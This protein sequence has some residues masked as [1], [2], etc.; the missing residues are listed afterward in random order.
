[1]LVL[2]LLSFLLLVLAWPLGN[3]VFPFH[4]IQALRPLLCWARI[5]SGL[6]ILAWLLQLQSVFYALSPW[7]L[8][9]PAL[10]SFLLLTR[11]RLKIPLREFLWL[12]LCAMAASILTAGFIDYGDSGIYHH[13]AMAWQSR[14]GAVP[15][16]AL[17]CEQYGYH[18]SW[19]S[20]PAPFHHGFLT[21]HVSSLPATLMTA[22]LLMG[23]TLFLFPKRSFRHPTLSLINTACLL[24]LL[25]LYS[26]AVFNSPNPD[27]GIFLGT[28][29]L[30]LGILL[31]SPA[32]RPAILALSIFVFSV[33]GS[34]LIWIPIAYFL[35]R[36]PFKK[37]LTL[38]LLLPPAMQSILLSGALF[39]PLPLLPFPVSWAPSFSS[40]LDS[41]QT[42]RE[43][44]RW[45]GF[46]PAGAKPWDW[47]MGWTH[48]EPLLSFSLSTCLV[49]YL[50]C[51]YQTS[52]SRHKRLF[53]IILGLLAFSFFS[54][55]TWR[56]A[57]AL[58]TLP[59][60]LWIS[61]PRFSQQKKWFLGLGFL[62]VGYLMTVHH[63]HLR[64][65]PLWE[66]LEARRQRDALFMEGARRMDQNQSVSAACFMEAACQK[67]PSG[68]ESCQ[69]L[70]VLQSRFHPEDWQD[71]YT[72]KENQAS[73]WL[74]THHSPLAS[75]WYLPPEMVY[76]QEKVL[77]S[78]HLAL[79][80]GEIDS[81]EI[82]YCWSAPLP[83]LTYHNATEWTYRDQE[84]HDLRYGFTRLRKSREFQLWNDQPYRETLLKSG[85]QNIQETAQRLCQ[86]KPGGLDCRVELQMKTLKVVLSNLGSPPAFEPDALDGL[87]QCSM[88]L[89]EQNWPKSLACAHLLKTAHPEWEEARRLYEGLIEEV[90]RRELLRV[91]YQSPMLVYTLPTMP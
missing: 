80:A 30:A 63:L 56:Y 52:F 8:L 11:L 47:L 4:P 74:N 24:L 50:S 86:Q 54:S 41:T 49:F 46:P 90:P 81:Q 12:L 18:S 16:L 10:S 53:L 31:T 5:G 22:L 72:L 25:F 76:S 36:T 51:R 55:P 6:L 39:A 75:H 73:E 70:E 1:M 48:R 62:G 33:K 85:F 66:L 78:T 23:S 7:A 69:D 40:L 64:G 88:L 27:L 68:H 35:D 15:G 58:A 59:A 65:T 29:L 20:L 3:L 57:A 28:L 38:L 43:F 89:K 42:I 14:F 2:F 84:S 32:F 71:F 26:K 17:L 21:H 77:L 79:A 61:L 60:A 67:S 82:A 13:Q 45:A 37:K 44:S 87:K 34:A 9:L 19:L 83:C 91:F